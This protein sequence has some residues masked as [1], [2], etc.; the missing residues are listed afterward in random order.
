MPFSF[1]DVLSG[2]F[3][4][5][6]LKIKIEINGVQSLWKKINIPALFPLMDNSLQGLGIASPE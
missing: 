6:I 3:L 4:S 5:D 1:T 2:G